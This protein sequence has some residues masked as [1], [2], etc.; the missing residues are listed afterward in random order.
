MATETRTSAPKSITANGT[1]EGQYGLF[2]KWEIEMENGDVGEYMSKD[3]PQTKFSVGMTTEYD[4]IT[5]NV[6]GKIFH[7]I[8]PVKKEFTP[9]G[10][11]GGRSFDPG[12]EIKIMR[13]SSLK[14]AVDLVCNGKI[15]MAD[16]Y[17]TIEAF[18]NYCDTGN[19]P[20]KNNTGL[21]F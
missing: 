7:N 19:V 4:F 3:Q 18:V 15:D 2:Y 14:A 5:K 20:E 21:P 9:G 11:G 10:G 17:A 16:L 6:G 13:Q 12:R 8:K 1:W